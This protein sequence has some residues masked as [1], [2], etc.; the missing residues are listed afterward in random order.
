[1]KV[2]L[3]E[4]F[5]RSSFLP[6]NLKITQLQ[7]SFITVQHKQIIIMFHFHHQTNTAIS[8]HYHINGIALA[9]VA[10]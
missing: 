3:S 1:M 6:I 4:N 8:C 5:N 10:T 7:L 2:K 9:A